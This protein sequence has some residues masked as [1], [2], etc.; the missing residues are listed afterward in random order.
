[1]FSPHW[2]T[3][4]T[5]PAGARPRGGAARPS[6][7]AKRQAVAMGWHAAG[8]SCALVGEE[9]GGRWVAWVGG[10]GFVWETRGGGRDATRARDGDG[11]WASVV[12]RRG[13]GFWAGRAPH[14]VGSGIALRIVSANT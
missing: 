10:G 7:A 6:G 3:A 11:G 13:S 5:T 8:G 12:E 9:L 2:A 1:M 14:V 4:T